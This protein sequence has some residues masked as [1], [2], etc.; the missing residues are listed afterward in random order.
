ME[1]LELLVAFYSQGKASHELIHQLLA[2]ECLDLAHY[3]VKDLGHV[4]TERLVVRRMQERDADW[5]AAGKDVV[6]NRFVRRARRAADW[7][8]FLSRCGRLSAIDLERLLGEVSRALEHCTPEV[9][10]RVARHFYQT[11]PSV[12]CELLAL[13]LGWDEREVRER[14]SERFLTYARAAEPKL[15]LLC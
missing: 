10:L 6:S 15:P 13:N 7:V 11:C 1:H 9:R 4:A 14:F 2:D 8:E 3:L 12:S 5:R